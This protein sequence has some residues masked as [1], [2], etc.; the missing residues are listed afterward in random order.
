MV[1]YCFQ[2]TGKE[3]KADFIKHNKS[4]IEIN[5]RQKVKENLCS[6]KI[7]N[8]KGKCCLGDIR[9]VIK[10]IEIED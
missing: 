2:H 5:V 9:K 10:G 3:I 1:C 6:C 8:P 7:L 4:L